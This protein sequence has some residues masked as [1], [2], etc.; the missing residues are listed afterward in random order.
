MD[1][2]KGGKK[3]KIKPRINFCCSVEQGH[4][5]WN[6]RGL[7]CQHTEVLVVEV[8]SDNYRSTVRFK[9][10]HVAVCVCKVF[11]SFSKCLYIWLYGSHT[12]STIS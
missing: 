7:I 5:A 9:V 10:S 8:V 11:V 12:G 2:P 4:Q 1:R 6:C 3:K